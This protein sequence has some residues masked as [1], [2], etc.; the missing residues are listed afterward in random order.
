MDDKRPTRPPSL[1]ALAKRIAH[2]RIQTT[3]QVLNLLEDAVSHPKFYTTIVAEEAYNQIC[4]RLSEMSPPASSNALVRL[5]LAL[6]RLTQRRGL[7]AIGFPPPVG[8]LSLIERELARGGA[9]P[10]TQAYI[11]KT[12][13]GARVLAFMA[14]ES[15][16]RWVSSGRADDKSVMRIAVRSVRDLRVALRE[17]SNPMIQ[18]GKATR[19]MVASLA[20]LDRLAQYYHG[21]PQ[22]WT[23]LAGG[24]EVDSIEAWRALEA[25][26]QKSF[27]ALEAGYQRALLARAADTTSTPTDRPGGPRL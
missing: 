12:P 10:W 4:D 23:R 2:P 17:E 3:E 16:E 1:G 9:L 14:P 26:S 8:C 18:E 13:G 24:V 27:P 7:M 21:E 11:E 20:Q 19:F 25:K 22:I 6:G 5:S 15:F